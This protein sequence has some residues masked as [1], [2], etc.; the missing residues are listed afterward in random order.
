[1]QPGEGRE[2][3]RW[4]E[5]PARGGG[6]LPGCGAGAGGG[7]RAAGAA[8]D[9]G[10][11]SRP[12]LSAPGPALT[13]ARGAGPGRGR[14]EGREPLLRAD[15]EGACRPPPWR[16]SLSQRRP[17]PPGLGT[18]A[19]EAPKA[20]KTPAEAPS[21]AQR[22]PSRAGRRGPP[23]NSLPHTPAGP[24]PYFYSGA[25]AG[26]LRSP[27]FL[28]VFSCWKQSPQCRPSTR[29]VLATPIKRN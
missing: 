26:G 19:A 16:G 8:R 20:K 21:S 24:S 11:M 27:E 12:A 9:L 5:A 1:M 28:E 2:W 17:G 18:K 29:P 6:R 23:R 14:G 25:G 4:W 13:Q 7:R 10:R 3:E 22:L 15:W